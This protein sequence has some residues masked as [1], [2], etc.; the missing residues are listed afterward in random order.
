VPCARSY[1]IS[2]FSE[3]HRNKNTPIHDAAMSG[4]DV[5][6]ILNLE[7]SLEARGEETAERSDDGCKE[8]HAERVQEEGVECH[9]L[10]H[11]IAFSKK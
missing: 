3:E 9:C 5:A 7:G 1:S 11:R 8:G 6:K 10:L 4:Y 2:N